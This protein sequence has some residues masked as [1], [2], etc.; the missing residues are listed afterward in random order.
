[1]QNQLNEGKDIGP[2]NYRNSGTSVS[3]AVEWVLQNRLQS[4]GIPDDDGI[5]ASVESVC[6]MSVFSAISPWAEA[7]LYWSASSS[8][9]SLTSMRKSSRR[10]VRITSVDFN[11]CILDDI[12]PDAIAECQS[13]LRLVDRPDTIF[14]LI[15]SYSGIEHDGLGRYGDPINP[16]GDI[17]AMLEMWLLT[18]SGGIL[19]VRYSMYTTRGDL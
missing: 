3:K 13:T 5:G 7:I 12:P 14:D 16:N 4:C 8:T 11:P 15:V 17:S 9:Q 6:H 1:M 10:N 2:P 18:R 19:L